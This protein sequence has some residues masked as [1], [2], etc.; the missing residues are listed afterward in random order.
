M[1]MN[2]PR[3]SRSDDIELTLPFGAKVRASGKQ[4]TLILVVIIGVC[5]ILYLIR[6][7]DLRSKG[8]GERILV[9]QQEMVH[10]MENIGYILTLK[11]EQRE[12]LKL[13][14]PPK[15]RKQLLESERERAR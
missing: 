2:E 6:E 1:Q 12:A 3:Q 7:H 15:L 13:D 4:V 10:S 11:Q 14:M 8:A 5:A 9:Q